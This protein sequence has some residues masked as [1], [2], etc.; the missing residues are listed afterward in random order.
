MERVFVEM[1]F[2]CRDAL[3]LD[4]VA[5]FQIVSLFQFLL[6]FL[7]ATDGILCRSR[8]LILSFP[9]FVSFVEAD[10]VVE[11]CYSVRCNCN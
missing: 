1:N 3:C 9:E 6:R 10:I 8:F 2:T 4:S 11:F 7:S 5:I